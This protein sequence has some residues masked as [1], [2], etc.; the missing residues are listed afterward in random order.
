MLFLFRPGT[1]HEDVNTYDLPAIYPEEFEISHLEVWGLGP[2]TDKDKERSKI[3][4]RKP[5]L[6]IRGGQVDMD[7]L[8]GQIG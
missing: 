6:Q 5:N 2:E 7:D 3:H 8:L 4:V 1:Y